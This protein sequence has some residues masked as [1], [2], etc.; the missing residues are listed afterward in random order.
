MVRVVNHLAL[1]EG[2]RR[3][4]VTSGRG[5]R[6]T[7]KIRGRNFHRMDLGESFKEE[8]KDETCKACAR[9]LRARH[10]SFA[11]RSRRPYEE[12]QANLHN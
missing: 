4:R 12:C 10:N 2:R 5:N 3:R 1:A 8:R 9:I 11:I 7:K 6:E